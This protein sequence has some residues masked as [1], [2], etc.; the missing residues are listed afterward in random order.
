MLEQTFGQSDYANAA[1]A[2]R[3]FRWEEVPEVRIFP[4]FAR[5]SNDLLAEV[6]A[7]ATAHRYISGDT[8]F[9]QGEDPQ[10]LHVVIDG[11]IGLFGT[12]SDGEETVVN[13]LRSGEIFIAAAALTGR[14]YLMSAKALAPSRILALPAER[15]RRDLQS[16]PDLAAGMLEAMSTHFRTLVREVKELKLKTSAQ[17]LGLYLLSLTPKRSGSAVAWLPHSKRVIAARIGIRPETLSRNL[18]ALQQY[19]VQ[20]SATKVSIA[21]LETLAAFCHRDDEVI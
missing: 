18:A 9:H 13:I 10:S 15:L 6:L 14:P 3:A 5:L 16:V 8:L 19:G 1:V 12:A 21:D 20:V 4:L 2:G 17:R 7:A 11:E